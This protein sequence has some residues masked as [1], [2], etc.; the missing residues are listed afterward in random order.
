[1]MTRK[2]GVRY[3]W[4]D[5]L[6]IIQGN[7]ADGQLES[8]RMGDVYRNSYLTITASKAAIDLEGFQSLE[9]FRMPR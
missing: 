3:L 1:M 8:S 4:V 6:C 2:L 5:S 7:T 9:I